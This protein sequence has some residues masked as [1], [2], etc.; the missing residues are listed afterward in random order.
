MGSDVSSLISPPDP[1]GYDRTLDGLFYINDLI[2]AKYHIWSNRKDP[3]KK[4]QITLIYSNNSD[5]DIGT[6]D[7]YYSLLRD[8]LCVNVLCFEY[9]GFGLYAA[10]EKYTEDCFY[11]TLR[12]VIDWVE[13]D[14]EVPLSDIILMGK[15]FGTGPIVHIC[16]DIYKARDRR[17]KSRGIS[18]RFIQA[19]TSNSSPEPSEDFPGFAG[20]FLQSPI[21][22][23]NSFLSYKGT[24]VSRFK[25]DYFV[26]IEKCKYILC[27][28]IVCYKESRS[29]Y[30]ESLIDKLYDPIAVKL[31]DDAILDYDDLFL[32]KCIELIQKKTVEDIMEV[33]P[34]EI[35]ER[36]KNAG[37][38][39]LR[40]LESLNFEAYFDAFMRAGLT[41][42]LML[43]DLMEFELE[44]MEISEGDRKTI[45]DNLY[46]KRL[47]M[48][49][50]HILVDSED[51]S[52][53]FRIFQ[54][55]SYDKY[56]G[57]L[58]N[59]NV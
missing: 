4:A 22:S 6:M 29:K 47:E 34:E 42:M 20:I 57:K 38:D 41:S 3:S 45:L 46:I 56:V 5:G 55:N 1:P 59:T 43:Y 52:K 33:V 26:N 54:R 11:S 2:P 9:P 25:S 27:D 51:L 37:G 31:E 30:V 36:Y 35:P 10:P 53:E 14:R 40:W 7:S 50:E 15:Y 49:F 8:S 16:S 58:N 39:V 17:T 19:I 32:D 23:I 12:T 44:A 18:K 21:C 28:S 24:G 13:K 48:P